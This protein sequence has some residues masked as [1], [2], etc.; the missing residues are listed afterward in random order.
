[1]EQVKHKSRTKLTI[2]QVVLALTELQHI[3]GRELGRRFGVSH[4]TVN[5]VRSGKNWKQ[6]VQLLGLPTN[7]Y[8]K[9]KPVKEEKTLQS[10]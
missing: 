9:N 1:M 3:S 5:N 10:I 8:Q 2:E 7:L 6:H 4:S